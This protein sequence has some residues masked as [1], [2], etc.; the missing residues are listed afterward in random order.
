VSEE[1]SSGGVQSQVTYTWEYDFCVDPKRRIQVPARWRPKE[2][3]FQFTLV[4]WPHHGIHEHCVMVLPPDR[5]QA[6]LSNMILKRTGD[7][8]AESLQRSLG[9]NAMTM[10][11]DSAGRLILPERMISVAALEG[12][13]KLVG[14]VTCFQIWNPKRL[15]KVEILDQAGIGDSLKLLNC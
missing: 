4:L 6:L 2:P 11:L 8:Q 15:E 1:L 14:L 7:P 10:E 12:Q 5:F 13:V 9:R 3:G